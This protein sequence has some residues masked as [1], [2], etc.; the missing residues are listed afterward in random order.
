MTGFSQPITVGAQQFQLG[1][2]IGAAVFP[3]DGDEG[4]VLI[5][6]ADRAM[7]AAKASGG[8]CYRLAGQV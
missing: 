8:N 1:M 2:S 3:A 5:S 6:R 4:E 7:Y